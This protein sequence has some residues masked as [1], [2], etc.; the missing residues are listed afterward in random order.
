MTLGMTLVIPVW[1]CVPFWGIHQASYASWYD[2]S[3]DAKTSG[4]DAMTLDL[5]Y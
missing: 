5:L 2:A 3:H 4:N 1:L